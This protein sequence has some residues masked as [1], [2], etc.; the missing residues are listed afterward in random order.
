M[1]ATPS[2][3]VAG[4]GWHGIGQPRI[5]SR[6]ISAEARGAQR[7]HVGDAPEVRADDGRPDLFAHW[8]V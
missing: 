5:R 1:P 4:R 2:A 3:K 8:A 7:A 6:K